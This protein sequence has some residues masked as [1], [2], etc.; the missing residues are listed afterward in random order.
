LNSILT[1]AGFISHHFMSADT[2]HSFLLFSM[3]WIPPELDTFKKKTDNIRIKVILRRVRV[4][5]I[6]A[7]N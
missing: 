2:K 6:A 1:K 4:T 3:Q 7:E 5:I